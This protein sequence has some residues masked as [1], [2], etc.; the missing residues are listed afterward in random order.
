MKDSISNNEMQG[1]GEN[2]VATI[3]Y[4]TYCLGPNLRTTLYERGTTLVLDLPTYFLIRDI[5]K[6]QHRSSVCGTFVVK[7]KRI[8]FL[9]NSADW[10]CIGELDRLSTTS[11]A[12]PQN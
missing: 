2:R 4:S 10:V 7:S 3:Y 6:T 8:V 1:Q 11:G 9:L 5:L 12:N